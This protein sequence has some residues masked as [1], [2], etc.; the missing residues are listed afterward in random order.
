MKPVNFDTKFGYIFQL[1]AVI[2]RGKMHHDRIYLQCFKLAPRGGNKLYVG[3]LELN[4]DTKDWVLG[5]SL[6][7]EFHP[8]QQTITNLVKWA[9]QHIS[10]K[11]DILL[12]KLID[13]NDSTMA[14]D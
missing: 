7:C 12:R 4:P 13:D 9:N 1:V 11:S 3:R 2:S 10:R 6:G 5:I 8:S 14:Q